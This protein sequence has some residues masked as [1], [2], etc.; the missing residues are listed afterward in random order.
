MDSNYDA[1]GQQRSK[2]DRTSEMDTDDVPTKESSS[3]KRQKNRANPKS[4]FEGTFNG[5]RV[6][7]WEVEDVVGKRGQGDNV[8]YK[9]RW[10]GCD[11]TQDS[12]EP[13]KYLCDTALEHAKRWEK[14][15]R[16]QAAVEEG[17]ESVET[18]KS[19][20]PFVQ[21]GSEVLEVVQMNL[22][23]QSTSV[24]PVESALVET[25]VRVPSQ[26]AL[27]EK[28]LSSQPLTSRPLMQDG[29][30]V[31]NLVQMNEQPLMRDGNGAVEA[32]QRN[33]PSQPVAHQKVSPSSWAWNVEEQVKI[34]PVRRI[35]VRDG[36]ARERVDE[37]R[38]AGVPV[39][40]VGH[41]GWPEFAKRWKVK[42]NDQER[43]DS[44]RPLDLSQPFQLDMD[45]MIDD[46]GDEMVP[47]LKRNYDEA[48]PI[49][50]KMKAKYFLNAS[51]SDFGNAAKPSHASRKEK[52]YLH[53]WQ[54]PRFDKSRRN[55]C[56]QS[57]SQVMPLHVLGDDLLKYYSS[58][59]SRSDNNPYQ[60]LFMGAR[61]TM[62]KLHRDCGGLAI[63]IAPIVGEKECVMVH[64]ADG[65]DCLYNLD[66]SLETVDLQRFPLMGTA[67]VW[68]T[69]VRPGEILLMP[70]GTY[71]QC[72]N[73]TACLS[74]SRF[75]LDTVNIRAFL[76]SM[77]DGDAGE[78]EHGVI[79]F[80]AAH[81]LIN[82]VEDFVDE[83][84]ETKTRR[85][86]ILNED[87]MQVMDDLR[88]L[89]NISH[90]IRRRKH[91]AHQPDEEEEWRDL[92]RDI[93]GCF[94]YCWENKVPEFRRRVSAAT[95]ARSDNALWLPITDSVG[96]S[97]EKAFLHLPNTPDETALS[98]TTEPT[99]N[100]I[101]AV[102]LMGK[103][104][105]GE[106]LEVRSGLSAA[107]VSYDGFPSELFNEYQP[108]HQLRIPRSGESPAEV[109]NENVMP[110]LVVFAKIGGSGE[111]RVVASCALRMNA[112]VAYRGVRL[113]IL[114]N[115]VRIIE[116]LYNPQLLA[117]SI[118]FDYQS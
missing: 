66:A 22:S 82:K 103:R 113:M 56:D 76:Q 11:E 43:D 48:N 20:H 111:V 89:R 84:A 8:E 53:Q 95:L 33:V 73:V 71:H 14:K 25:N 105:K 115:F 67:R 37:A 13:E 110:G 61:G 83:Q 92:T 98:Q 15:Q 68:K 101:V 102:H 60:Y 117:P 78:V 85:Q 118:A 26:P 87:M 58:E 24:S 74:Y 2:R 34:R 32:A 6:K 90:E 69:I 86:I 21:A 114:S 4:V 59:R 42:T 3:Q 50:D 29:R 18:N 38:E 88:C 91:L 63:T 99:K 106:I 75:H 46:I 64:R 31:V 5:E 109:K 55:L 104:V 36:D 44:C 23:T 27:V 108:F 49:P 100:D 47:I 107:L 45:S 70:Q 17:G 97:L 9:V 16:E 62:S 40:L 80:N 77:C 81:S 93:D 52:L 28:S 96:S 30:P 94:E 7:Y 112:T 35:N 1:D 41:V 54:F 65:E 116:A 12:W 39:V 19:S 10:K 51:R 72:R 57:E 79:L